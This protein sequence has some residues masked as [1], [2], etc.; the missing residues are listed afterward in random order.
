MMFWQNEDCLK[1]MIGKTSFCIHQKSDVAI[2]FFMCVSELK[3]EITGND[4]KLGT[5]G[6]AE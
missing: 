4:T 1:I 3:S 6:G 5:G 2:I